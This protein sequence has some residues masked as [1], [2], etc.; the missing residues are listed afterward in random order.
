MNARPLIAICGTT[1]VGKSNLSIELALALADSRGIRKHGW[2]GARIINADSMQVYA[3]MDVIT[4]KVP[5]SGRQGVE[6]LL[7]SFKKPG[8]QYVVGDWV[9]DAIREI[10]ETHAQHKIPIVVGG[11]SYWIQHLIFPDRLTLNLKSPRSPNRPATPVLSDDLAQSVS[12]LPQEAQDLL[13][14]LP[15]EPPDA[16]ADPRSAFS[17]Y[18]LLKNLDPTAASRWHWRD[19]RKVLR[20]LDIIKE[21]GRKPSD[22]WNE[23]AQDDVKPRYRTL[24]FWLYAEPSALNPRLDARVD[25]MIKH[26]LLDEILSLQKIAT[27]GADLRIA[28]AVDYTLGIYQAIGYKE[29]HAYLNSP[30]RSEEAF[31][32]AVDRMKLSTKQYAQRQV[33]WIRNK[34]LPAVYAAQ[35]AE[36]GK[37]SIRA[38]LLDATSVDETWNVN[39]N[40]KGKAIMHDFLEERPLPDPLELSN[41]ARSM[42]TIPGSPSSP[43]VRRKLVCDVCTTNTE[44]PVMI[45]EGEQWEV[46]RKTKAHKM[47][48]TREAR[49]AEVAKWKKIKEERMERKI[50]DAAVIDQ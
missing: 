11:T 43:I 36:G 33:K 49:W 17:L 4:N 39:V 24:C 19:T 20:S 22:I 38:Y 18:D 13:R 21:T 30:T 29:F 15:Q 23:Q 25:D 28:P 12:S 9:R 5:E 37:E 32:D 27:A 35:A 47:M 1:G 44:E 8:E 16:S 48:A 42:L 46:H 50:T 41:A 3:G 14:D 10:H 31:R 34:L 2:M 26:G 45:E 7:M 40:E 6:H